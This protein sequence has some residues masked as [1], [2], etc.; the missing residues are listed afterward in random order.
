MSHST[1]F[2]PQGLSAVPMFDL[3]RARSSGLGGFFRAILNS[4]P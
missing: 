3:F 1:Y 4:R 2:G